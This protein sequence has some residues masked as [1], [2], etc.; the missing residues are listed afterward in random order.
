MMN[1][2]YS[3]TYFYLGQV[4][5]LCWQAKDLVTKIQIKEHSN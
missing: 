1:L 3:D 2:K 4:L 5:F